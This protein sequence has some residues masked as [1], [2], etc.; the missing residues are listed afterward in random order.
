MYLMHFDHNDIDFRTKVFSGN[1]TGYT[2]VPSLY[3]LC[4]RVLIE[5]IDGKIF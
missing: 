5:N 2:N 1:K 3:E 4:I